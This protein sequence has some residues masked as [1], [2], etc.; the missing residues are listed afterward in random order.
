MAS[1]TLL[2]AGCPGG[3]GAAHAVGAGK[4]SAV[5][6][7]LSEMPLTEIDPG[8]SWKSLAISPDGSQVAYMA[9]RGDRWLVVE[10]GHESVEYDAIVTPGPIFSPDSKRLAY[11]AI[12]GDRRFAVVGGQAGEEWDGIV[13]RPGPSSARTAS[14]RPTWLYGTTGRFWW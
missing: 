13:W 3:V 14:T 4:T 10:D 11:V 5:K 9:Q 1:I 8:I 2:L 12:Q 6:L 7:T